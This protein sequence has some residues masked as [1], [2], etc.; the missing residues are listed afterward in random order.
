MDVFLGMFSL[1]GL[2]PR[3]VSEGVVGG[4]IWFFVEVYV[5]NICPPSVVGLV[6]SKVTEEV[7]G[8]VVLLFQ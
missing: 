6:H 2:V 5:F 7:L 1:V 8:V 4:I 3:R